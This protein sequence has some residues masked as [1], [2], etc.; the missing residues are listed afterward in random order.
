ML[1]RL[2]GAGARQRNLGEHPVDFGE[3]PEGDDLMVGLLRSVAR[4][5]LQAQFVPAGALSQPAGDEDRRLH[6]LDRH[7]HIGARRQPARAAQRARFAHEAKAPVGED[8]HRD[9]ARKA[10]DEQRQERADTGDPAMRE[11]PIIEAI[12]FGQIDPVDGVEDVEIERQQIVEQLH[13][14][15]DDRE[16]GEREVEQAR[17]EQPARIH[18]EEQP[19]LR[20]LAAAFGRGA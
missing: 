18:C 19:V 6:A 16:R 4:Q 17:D 9:P 20:G 10:D 11:H 12:A 8:H 14:R 5:A 15:A 3:P 7:R 13:R 1:P 2:A